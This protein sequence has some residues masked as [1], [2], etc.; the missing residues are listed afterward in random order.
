MHHAPSQWICAK[1]VAQ[2]KGFSVHKAS[3]WPMICAPGDCGR[4][5][6]VHPL[7]TPCPRTPMHTCHQ[8]QGIQIAPSR[9]PCT[10][11]CARGILVHQPLL[12]KTAPAPRLY[13][14]C[15]IAPVHP[16]N[17][18]TRIPMHLPPNGPRSVHKDPLR[19][20]CGSAQGTFAPFRECTGKPMCTRITPLHTAVCAQSILVQS[21]ERSRRRSWCIPRQY[22]EAAECAQ[23]TI[24]PRCRRTVAPL[25]KRLR[26]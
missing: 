3:Q 1:G 25:H 23:G 26:E 4:V 10:R 16:D 11:I 5:A 7:A 13:N 21:G 22:P 19:D 18:C 24:P 6:L 15:T 14:L 12:P 8:V 20:H 17:L 9:G 2:C